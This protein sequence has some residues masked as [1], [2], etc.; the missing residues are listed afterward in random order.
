MKSST[1]RKTENL[2]VTGA[3]V[4][5]SL[6]IYLRVVILGRKRPH[7]SELSRDNLQTPPYEINDETCLGGR[8]LDSASNQNLPESEKAVSLNDAAS[9]LTCLDFQALPAK[10]CKS[11]KARNS[12]I[13]PLRVAW[14]SSRN[15]NPSAL[16]G[17]EI[18]QKGWNLSG[19]D[20]R[21]I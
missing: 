7:D 1:I 6:A 15:D 9:H 12:S 18:F 5:S 16:F 20:R 10:F 3:D 19:R 11:A 4:L 21:A 13:L 8:F 17:R 2:T 14:N